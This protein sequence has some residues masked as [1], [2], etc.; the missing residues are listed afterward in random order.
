M[1]TQNQN[2]SEGISQNANLVLI[3]GGLYASTSRP[4]LEFGLSLSSK[5]KP[6]VLLVPTAKDK[7]NTFATFS[8]KAQHMY[9]EDIGTPVDILHEFEDMPDADELKKKFDKADVLYM[10][11]GNSRYA[12]EQWRQYGIDVMITDAMRQGK[13]ITGISAGALALF[14]QGFSDSEHYEVEKGEPWKFTELEGLG[15]IDTIVSPHFNSTETP[16]GRLRSQHFAEAL[17]SRSETSGL[18]EFGLGIDNTAALFATGGLIKIIRTKPDQDVHI[19]SS[20]AAG[21]YTQ[22]P[23]N[24]PKFIISETNPSPD[25]VTDD[26]ITWEDF[27]LQLS[28]P[29]KNPRVTASAS[30]KAS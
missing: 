29:A 21:N 19:V 8:R 3:G 11:G 6:N 18:R 4:L 22:T 2:K 23:I 17:R 27:Y 20:D 10:A 13:I 5:S 9:G 28:E 14:N 12:L 24:A 30:S 25:Q 15:H 16:D 7:A 26:G 1:K